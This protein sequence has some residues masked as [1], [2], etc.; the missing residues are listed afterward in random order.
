[1]PCRLLRTLG[2][3]LDSVALEDAFD[4]CFADDMTE[5]GQRSLDPFV[6]PCVVYGGHA[7]RQTPDA[8]SN[9]WFTWATNRAAVVLF[10]DELPVPSQDRVGRHDAATRR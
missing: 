6:A 7:N 9:S 5:V 10:G 4:R 8:A 1:M 3:W 2:R